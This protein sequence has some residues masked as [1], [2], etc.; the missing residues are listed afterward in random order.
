MNIQ[1]V[2]AAGGYGVRM[3]PVLDKTPKILAPIKQHIETIP[4]L[5]LVL[6][7][8]QTFGCKSIHLLLGYGAAKIWKSVEEWKQKHKDNSELAISASIEPRLLGVMGA[9][10]FAKS[11]LSDL[12]L[13]TY[14]DVYP[15]I[16]PQQLLNNLKPSDE[17]CLAICTQEIAN[18]PANV[19]LENNQIAKYTKH[20]LSMTYVDLGAILLRKSALKVLPKEL[21]YPLNEQDLFGPLATRRTLSVYKHTKPSYHVGDPEAYYRFKSKEVINA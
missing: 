9:L 10:H 12:F 1:V 15:T 21:K 6:D 7:R 11:S 3:K 16:N 4:F 18:E 17:G 8:W 13:L 14:G 2:I 5:W 19:K 20:D